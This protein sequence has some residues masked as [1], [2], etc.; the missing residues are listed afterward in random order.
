ML[1]MRRVVMEKG[2]GC[3]GGRVRGQ[4]MCG[5]EVMSLSMLVDGGVPMEEW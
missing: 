3:S 1:A 5:Q 2:M 4:L